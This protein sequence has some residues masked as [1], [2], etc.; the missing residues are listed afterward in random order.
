M[1]LVI[2]CA[3]VV[4]GCACVVV[5]QLHELAYEKG[6]LERE[7]AFERKFGSAHEQIVLPSAEDMTAHGAT[8]T[9]AAAGEHQLM[10][11]LLAYELSLRE[12][13]V[14]E[15]SSLASRREELHAQVARKRQLLEDD[16]PRQ[17]SHLCAAAKPI[18]SFAPESG[19]TA[20]SV[21]LGLGN[22]ADQLPPPLFTLVSQF[23]AYRDE[24]ANT[25]GA[26]MTVC[27][28]GDATNIRDDPSGPAPMSKHRRK[29]PPNRTSALEPYPLW[30]EVVHC[31]GKHGTLRMTFTYLP[32]LNLLAADG[33]WLPSGK[34]AKKL[35]G[36]ELLAQLFEGD[37]GLEL[38]SPASV[39][40]LGSGSWPVTDAEA[41]AKVA[42]H[43]IGRPYRWLQWFGGLY[44]P[45]PTASAAPGTAEPQGLLTKTGETGIDGNGARGEEAS[46]S[47]YATL[48]R[49]FDLVRVK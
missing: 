14:G 1:T 39:H 17:L 18:A 49:I 8:S 29:D 25:S 42:A 21:A 46:W 9:A 40:V 3:C 26:D 28:R 22:G 35:T 37:H 11:E 31:D 13:L 12:Q 32:Q 38:P 45:R 36:P 27:I 5:E 47:V 43:A 2:G 23:E 10:L 48:G 7:I 44:A 16:L 6:H 4:I 34:R 41:A 24:F 30:A 33:E 20:D 15:E 19:Q